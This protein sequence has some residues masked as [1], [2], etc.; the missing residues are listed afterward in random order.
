[1]VTT[2]PLKFDLRIGQTIGCTL[3]ALGTILSLLFATTYVVGVAWRLAT[4]G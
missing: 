3:L 1:M 2:T 4:G